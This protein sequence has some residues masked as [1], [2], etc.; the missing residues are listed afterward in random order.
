MHE[1]FGRLFSSDGF[2]PRWK[3]GDWTSFHGWLYILSDL[4][5]WAAYT[6]IPA[7]LIYFVWRK[8]AIPFRGVFLLF[9][10]FILACGL[11]HLMDAI[12]FWW[13]AY[14]LLGLVE[15]CTAVVSWGTVVA[16][17]PIVP[18]ALSMRSPEELEREIEARRKAEHDLQLVNRDLERRIQA[19]T[20][21]L[22]KANSTLKLER[23]WFRTTLASIGDAVVATDTE[24]R[25]TFFNA[26]AEALTG[27]DAGAAVGQPL[28]SAFTIINEDT[29]QPAANPAVRALK[30]GRIV[31][32]ANHT[33]LI[34]KSGNEQPIDD[35]A[36]PIRDAEGSV[37][38]VVLVFRDVTERRQSELALRQSE[39]QLRAADR[40][41]DEFLAVLAH[42]L[43]NP[44]APIRN[45]LELLAIET[46]PATAVWARDLM[47]R[48]VE[49]IVRLVDDLLDVSRITQGKIQLKKEP[50]E[51]GAAIR[52]TADEIKPD[53]KSASSGFRCLCPASPFGRKQ[54]RS[55]SRK[56]FS[57]C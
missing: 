3:C 37:V 41:K 18:R 15:F 40:R 29:R 38:G 49:H 34:S 7:V 22:V 6:A 36:A 45:A 50:V 20:A 26:V 9:G 33:L 5:V 47:K 53:L 42:E 14:R 39:E 56:S 48:Q 43:R 52:H 28:E 25:I 57:I 32:L 35:S 10:A 16:L 8:A 31:G 55:D 1:F 11:T 4:G 19:R 44:L 23:E 27:W 46:D 21:E 51:V 30:E 2:M 24:G 17:V 12:M 13:P 54:T